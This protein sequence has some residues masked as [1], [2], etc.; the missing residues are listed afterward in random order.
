MKKNEPTLIQ[1]DEIIDGMPWTLGGVAGKLRTKIP[2][3]PRGTPR[4][5]VRYVHRADAE[6]R[7]SESYLRQRR[8]LGDDF[9]T[10]LT[11]DFD[12]MDKI[13]EAALQVW[14]HRKRK[15]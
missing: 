15:A 14:L 4:P 5:P 7:K 13:Y 1:I 10:D 8:K 11:E 6:G 9:D 2:P 12:E 3:H